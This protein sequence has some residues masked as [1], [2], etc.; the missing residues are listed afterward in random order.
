MSA[1]RDWTTYESKPAGTDLISTGDDEIRSTK[2]DIRQRMAVDHL[3]GDSVSTDGY[4][5]QVTMKSASDPAYIAGYGRTYV[6]TVVRDELFYIDEAGNKVQITDSGTVR[7]GTKTVDESAI[8]DGYLLFYN[9]STGKIEYEIAPTP[10]IPAGM[11][12]NV[13][14]KMTSTNATIT[15]IIPVDNTKPQISEGDQIMF[16]AYT[17]QSITNNLLITVVANI[18]GDS[19]GNVN[20]VALFQDSNA[21]ALAC[22]VGSPWAGGTF[23]PIVFNWFMPAGTVSSTTFKVRSGPQAS[24]THYFNGTSAGARFNGTFASSITITEIKA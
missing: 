14:N 15:T 3:W 2:V 23:A 12:V 8:A 21:D 10:T 1:S 22:S 5:T 24:A 19:G 18:C 17:P 4:H 16:L 11:V 13:A 7:V 9:A 20:T 6:K